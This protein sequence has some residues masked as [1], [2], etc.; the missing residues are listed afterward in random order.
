MDLDRLAD[1]PPIERV[2]II[3]ENAAIW[4]SHL[5]RGDQELARH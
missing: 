2:E 1:F 5:H 4:I 3:D